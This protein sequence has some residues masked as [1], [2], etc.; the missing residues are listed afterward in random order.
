VRFRSLF[1][2]LALIILVALQF[3]LYVDLQLHFYIAWLL[4]VSLTT[5]LFYWVDKALARIKKFNIRVPEL[6]L[7]LLTLAGGFVGAWIGR[8]LFRHKTNIREHWAMLVILILSTVLHGGLIYLVFFRGF[9][10]GG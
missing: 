7:N 10:W 6:V 9:E 3:T 4:N 5:F 1:V 2:V 8:A